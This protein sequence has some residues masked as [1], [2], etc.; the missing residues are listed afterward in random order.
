MMAQRTMTAIIQRGAHNVPKQNQGSRRWE[1]EGKSG[2]QL[3][4]GL[5][6]KE[7]EAS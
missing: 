2:G 4:L 1:V 3:A 6:Q 7:M 5:S